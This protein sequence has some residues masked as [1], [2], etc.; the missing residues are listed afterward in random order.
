[1]LHNE[2]IAGCGQLSWDSQSLVSAVDVGSLRCMDSA[3]STT[4]GA[5]SSTN[6]FDA[7]SPDFYHVT[8]PGDELL[9][10][11]SCGKLLAQRKVQ[12]TDAEQ[13]VLAKE[14]AMLGNKW[15]LFSHLRAHS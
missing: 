5:M 13:F 10:A 7:G 3:V 8:A 12:W 15:V 4:G 2:L 11:G 1:M 9:E 14:H 6:Y